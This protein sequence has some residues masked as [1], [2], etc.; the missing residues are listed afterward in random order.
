MK[1]SAMPFQYL[2][3]TL[4]QDVLSV[5]DLRVYE[6]LCLSTVCSCFLTAL[7]I[8]N[9]D[10]DLTTGEQWHISYTNHDNPEPL[11]QSDALNTIRLIGQTGHR[12]VS[13]Q[14]SI[15]G[16]ACVWV[17]IYAHD[18]F[19]ICLV[20]FPVGFQW[21]RKLWQTTICIPGLWINWRKIDSPWFI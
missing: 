18:L 21:I 19:E 5:C 17:C 3:S 9:R 15:K 6:W 12:W 10:R 14:Y 1:T 20:V 4:T 2:I 13:C 7:M 11:D 16:P 8:P